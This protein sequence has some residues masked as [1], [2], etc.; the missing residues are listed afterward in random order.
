MGEKNERLTGAFR[1]LRASVADVRR[2]PPEWLVLAG[3]FLAVVA[4]GALLVWFVALSG[5]SE[6]VQFVYGGF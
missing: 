1:K 4:G 5:L 6:P 2:Q 3:T